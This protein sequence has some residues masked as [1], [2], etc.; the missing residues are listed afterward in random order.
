MVQ[1]MVRLTSLTVDPNASTKLSEKQKAEFRIHSKIL[2]L[3]NRNKALTAQLKSQGYRLIS[4]A[5]GTLLYNE[6]MKAQA[7]LNS[8]KVRL[9]HS[10]IEKSRKRHFRKVDTIAFNLQFFVSSD[11]KLSV[12]DEPA[13]RRKY[14]IP[15][16]AE[17]VR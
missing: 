10:M 16:R 15:E 1:K 7:R 4:I 2:R 13:T 9:R 11:Q 3:S 5:K 17:I 6:K 12:S 14:N 8:Y